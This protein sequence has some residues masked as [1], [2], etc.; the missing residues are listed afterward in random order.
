ML[1]HTEALAPLV[2]YIVVIS[3]NSGKNNKSGKNGNSSMNS[4]DL[5]Y[6]SSTIIYS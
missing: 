5:L 6:S 4:N 1:Y 2:L 3:S